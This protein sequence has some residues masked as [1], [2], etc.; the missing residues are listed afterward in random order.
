MHPGNML[1]HRYVPT[2][3]LFVLA[4]HHPVLFSVLCRYR[5]LQDIT[6]C[7]FLQEYL[8]SAPTEKN[9]DGVSRAT[10][11]GFLD[12]SSTAAAPLW[13]APSL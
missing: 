8:S 6:L 5:F 2:L 11:G 3:P 9:D 12:L 4:Y 7:I 1:S 13:S 10:V